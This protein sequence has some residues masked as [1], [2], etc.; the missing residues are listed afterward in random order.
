MFSACSSVKVEEYA[1]RTPTMDI[2]DYFNGNVDAYGVFVSRSGKV[3][4]QFH[5]VMKGKWDGNNGELH[6]DFT[7]M[8]GKKEQRTWHF[9]VADNGQI[10]GTAHDVIGKAK[11]AQAG[12]AVNMKY[13]LRLPVKNTS[14][15]ISMDDW[16]YRMTD[17]IVVNRVKMTK[18]G[19]NVG[20]LIITFHKK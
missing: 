16:L 4:Q 19:F 13:V 15:D 9:Q 8:D 7:Y 10:T 14:Y 2:R 11:G 1:G 3:E 18:F 5:V 20:E 12:N 6:E 17:K